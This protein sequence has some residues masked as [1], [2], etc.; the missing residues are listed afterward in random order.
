M[1]EI[2][3]NNINWKSVI[4]ILVSVAIIS[5]IVLGGIYYYLDYSNHCCSC[6]S[7][8]SACCPCPNW[9]YVEDIK[10][11]CDDTVCGSSSYLKCCEEYKEQTGKEFDCWYE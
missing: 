9:D 1:F 10:A 4:S 7:T 2:K 8:D 6:G 5:A 11:N 3:S